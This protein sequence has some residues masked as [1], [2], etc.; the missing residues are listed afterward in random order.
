M[1]S[2]IEPAS[3]SSKPWKEKVYFLIYF[4]TEKVYKEFPL[5]SDEACLF[6]SEVG[7]FA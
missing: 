1:I 7:T 6:L 4:Q 2:V 3:L 5:A